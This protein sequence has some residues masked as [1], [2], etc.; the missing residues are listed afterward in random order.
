MAE[1]GGN[2][3]EMISDSSIDDDSMILVSRPQNKRSTVVDDESISDSSNYDDHDELNNAT[4]PTE[5]DN[6]N[7]NLVLDTDHV[8]S[9]SAFDEYIDTT[10]DSIEGRQVSCD[11][12]ISSVAARTGPFSLITPGKIDTSVNSASTD[13]IGPFASTNIRPGSTLNSE[14][15][16]Q[17]VSSV[18]F[19]HPI[20]LP[21]SSIVIAS[22]IESHC[23][24]AISIPVTTAVTVTVPVEPI[25]EASSA[26]VAPCVGQVVNVSILATAV[27]AAAAIPL[28][29]I[30]EAGRT[31]I[32]PIIPVASKSITSIA[33]KSVTSIRPT[34]ISTTA[35]I[36][37]VQPM[38]SV[39]ARSGSV[40]LT[41]E[42]Q[43]SGPERTNVSHNLSSS[44]GQNCTIRSVIRTNS[45]G[46]K[47]EE[48]ESAERWRDRLWPSRALT[49]FCRSITR[50][51]PPILEAGKNIFAGSNNRDGDKKVRLDPH[52]EKTDLRKVITSYDTLAAHNA[53]FFLLLVEESRESSLQDSSEFE[54]SV[55][56]LDLNLNF[57]LNIK[58]YEAVAL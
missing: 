28:K 15:S 11:T 22:V 34:P 39:R 9:M 40:D 24:L 37:A 19:D 46:A 3:P 31:I 44:S 20:T 1:S 58:I 18:S 54:A 10:S 17:P 25:A 30:V 47:E 6:F 5:T 16:A 55:S 29:S 49:S 27:V 36:G 48:K 23:A 7:V 57:N 42:K 52:W 43:Q 41:L 4:E 12:K 2:S 56:Y 38:V 21:S 13:R 32:K 51:K 45:S 53:A 26:R 35:T 8:S 50:C 33:T 14:A